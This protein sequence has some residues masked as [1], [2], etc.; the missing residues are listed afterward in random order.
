MFQIV[1]AHLLQTSWLSLSICSQQTEVP[2]AEKEEATMRNMKLLVIL[3]FIVVSID[4][5]STAKRKRGSRAQF[6]FFNN[7]QPK[8]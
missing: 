4:E 5:V 2:L 6:G 3:V 8:T 1:F 7:K